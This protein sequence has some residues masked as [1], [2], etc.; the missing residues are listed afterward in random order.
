V[1]DAEYQRRYRA[2]RPEVVVRNRALALARSRAL[3]QLADQHP[4]EYV[5]LL[6]AVC[7]AMGIDPPGVKPTGRPPRG[8]R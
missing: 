6:D 1:T 3:N 4:A 2:E 5:V 8:A 7:T